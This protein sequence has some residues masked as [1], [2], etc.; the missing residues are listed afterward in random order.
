[1]FTS[2]VHDS[3]DFLP[4]FGPMAE[5]VFGFGSQQSS[6][7]VEADAE[8]G[9][10]VSTMRF[11]RSF[12][13]AEFCRCCFCRP[14]HS[15]GNDADKQA[16]LFRNRQAGIL[17]IEALGFCFSEHAFDGPTRAIRCQGM[18]GWPIADNNQQLLSLDALGSAVHPNRRGVF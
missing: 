5:C 3:C 18:V 2:P 9:F 14:C 4:D 7:F 12:S 13:C 1:M 6:D 16:Q 11:S 8:D 10:G 15:Q 17:Q